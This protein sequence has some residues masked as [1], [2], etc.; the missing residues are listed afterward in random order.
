MNKQKEQKSCTPKRCKVGGQAVMEGVMMKSENGIAMAVRK[1]DG[2]IISEYTP[3]NNKPKKGSF[4]AWPVVRGVVAFIDSLKTGMNT[5]T[6]SAELYGESFEEE[7]PSK[8]EKFLAE[9]LGKSA[10]DI[11]IAIGVILAIALSCFLFVYLPVQGADLIL[12]TDSTVHNY[13]IYRSLIEGGI[14]L[15]IFIGYILLCSCIKDIK[16]VFMYHGAEHK[17][18]SCYEAGDELTPENAMK[19]SRLHPRCGTNYLFLVMAVSIVVF[20]VI[21]AFIPFN[22][23]TNRALRIILRLIIRLAFLPVVAGISYEIL[24]AAAKSDNILCKIVRAPGMGLQLITTKEPTEDMIEVA[25]CSFKLAMQSIGE[26]VTIPDFNA[27]DEEQ[28]DEIKSDEQTEE[29]NMTVNADI[30]AVYDDAD[31]LETEKTD[32]SA[33]SE[34][35]ENV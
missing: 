11:A 17:T 2:K 13:E 26:E 35:Q 34:N 30:G 21:S 15:L 4:K 24:Q 25:L 32:E 16:R 10:E 8:F 14:R 27:N 1:S 6:R 22:F 12:H 18:I 7:E 3:T 29:L 9:K 19:H 5:I 31:V 33:E 20:T 23:V 28:T